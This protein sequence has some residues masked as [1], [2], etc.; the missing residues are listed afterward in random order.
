M[1]ASSS[2]VSDRF[3]CM[4]KFFFRS[5]CL[6]F[7]A[8][9]STL[10]A[11]NLLRGVRG[12]LGDFGVLAGTAWAAFSG[13]PPLI[14]GKITE[15]L[16]DFG[17]LEVDFLLLGDLGVAVLDFLVDFAPRPEG[18]FE[19]LGDFRGF[20]PLEEADFLLRL[21][22]EVSREVGRAF[23][24]EAPELVALVVAEELAGVMNESRLA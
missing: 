9:L 18:V 13:K 6:N 1:M 24:G 8:L 14:F 15:A 19:A 12:D 4:T 2:S 20:L 3:S 23:F 16:G 21:E 11:S 10:R 7:L 5:I 17:V 22:A